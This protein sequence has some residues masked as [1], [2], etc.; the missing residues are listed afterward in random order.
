MR[1]SRI[2]RIISITAI[3]VV[4]LLLLYGIVRGGFGLYQRLSEPQEVSQLRELTI[5]AWVDIDLIRV[6][7]AARRGTSLE[8]TG[9]IVI[10][11]IGNPGTTAAQNRNYFN[12]P[13]TAVSAHFI[14]GLEGEIIQCVPLNE[15][16]SASNHRNADTISIEVCHPDESGVFTEKTYQSLVRLTAWLCREIGFSEEQI[17]RHHDVTGK[18]CPRWFVEDPEAWETFKQD[19][20]AA[21]NEKE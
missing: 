3:F 4:S 2:R 11:Y 21:A 17:I 20:S 18:N 5:P 14:V 19:V 13:G 15:K 1:H 9:G 7:G 16:S 10:H 12:S 8:S 6:D